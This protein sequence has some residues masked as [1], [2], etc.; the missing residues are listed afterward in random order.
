MQAL[1]M[2]VLYHAYIYTN[3]LFLLLK[4]VHYHFIFNMITII[5]VNNIISLFKI[6]IMIDCILVRDDIVSCIILLY[7]V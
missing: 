5:N 2:Y 3:I 6:C 1:S 7:F 4:I